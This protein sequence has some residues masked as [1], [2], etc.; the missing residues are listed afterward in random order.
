MFMACLQ[1]M[2]H[3]LAVQLSN[4]PQIQLRIVRLLK[5][6]I[7]Q[8]QLGPPQLLNWGALFVWIEDVL[9]LSAH[10]KTP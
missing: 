7:F 9:E 3:I 6:K 1:W 8:E 2:I 5:F 4:A 10:P